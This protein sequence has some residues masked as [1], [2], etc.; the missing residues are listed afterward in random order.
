MVDLN[1]LSS[2]LSFED[3]PVLNALVLVGVAV[4]SD[5]V[6]HPMTDVDSGSRLTNQISPIFCYTD[7][8][9]GMRCRWA[10]HSLS[11]HFSV[12]L[13]DMVIWRTE[14]VGTSFNLPSCMEV[15]TT[16]EGNERRKIY[17][18]REREKAETKTEREQT[19]SEPSDPVIMPQ[20]PT[21]PGISVTRKQKL[22]N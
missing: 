14:V 10:N 8:G 4:L 22:S 18:E 3:H 19:S 11:W 21:Y 17:F 15:L 2:I 13:G 7:L 12:W 9:V 1:C 6:S 16:V 5:I 20:G